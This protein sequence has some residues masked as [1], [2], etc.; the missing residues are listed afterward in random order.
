META[1][2]EIKVGRHWSPLPPG[3]SIGHATGPRPRVWSIQGLRPELLLL[4]Q[5]G[6][7]WHL[8]APAASAPSGL[9]CPLVD[10]SILNSQSW[11]LIPMQMRKPRR[12]EGPRARTGAH[13]SS[14]RTLSSSLKSRRSGMRR[15]LSPCSVCPTL[16]SLSVL[17]ST[18]SL[19]APRPQACRSWPSASPSVQRGGWRN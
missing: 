4:D 1:R 3:Q 11:N 14:D 7:T 8:P 18:Q 2:C 17:L 12:G 9:G 13:L 16:T 5:A 15:G 10:L 6:F 19:L